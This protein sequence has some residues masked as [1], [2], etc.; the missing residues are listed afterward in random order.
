VKIEPKSIG[1]AEAIRSGD[2]QGSKRYNYKKLYVV[3]HTDDGRGNL[4]HPLLGGK[5]GGV[6]A[7]GVQIGFVFK[8]GNQHDVIR[9]RAMEKILPKFQVDQFLNL[10]LH[11]S[12][13]IKMGR[14]FVFELF[15][16]LK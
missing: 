14:Q 4:G 12:K 6:V 13:G 15:L 1:N 10:S 11:L 5:M 9:A 2:P 16:N 7:I 3:V 8:G